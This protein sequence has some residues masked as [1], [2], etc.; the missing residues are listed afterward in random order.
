MDHSLLGL[1]DAAGERDADAMRQPAGGASDRPGSALFGGPVGALL[2]LQALAGNAAVLQLLEHG[3]GPTPAAPVAGSSDDEEAAQRE[4][5]ARAAAAGTDLGGIG[6]DPGAA[7]GVD[8]APVDDP[9]REHTREEQAAKRDQ[10]DASPQPEEHVEPGGGPVPIGSAADAGGEFVDGGRESSVPF[11]DARVDHLDPDRDLEPHAFTTG[12]KSGGTTWAGGGGAGP[13]GNEKT[14]SIQNQVDPV[15][16][17]QTVGPFHNANAW[18]AEGTGVADV[19]RSYVTSSPGDQGNGWW[20]SDKAA[21]ALESHEQKHVTGSKGVYESKIQPALDKVAMSPVLGLGKT[22][23]ASDAKALLARQVGW[24]SAIKGFDE[25][26][27]QVNAPGGVVDTEDQ[28]SP[29]YPRQRGPGQVSGKDFT[30]RLMLGSE[31]D[32]E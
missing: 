8:L 25:D 24:T 6:G 32:P 26:D 7:L 14:G 15:Y 10:D 27:K 22:Y 12:G 20:V 21:A 11:T 19:K 13:K 23:W 31:P 9:G 18:V 3:T 5:E 4:A 2:G 29:W 1:G 17:A 16:E 30:N 28:G